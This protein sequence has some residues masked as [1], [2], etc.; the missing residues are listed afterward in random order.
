MVVRSHVAERKFGDKDTSSHPGIVGVHSRRHH[1]F[2]VRRSHRVVEIDG[3]SL[4]VIAQERHFGLFRAFERHV[5][6]EITLRE[7][8]GES[9][10]KWSAIVKLIVTEPVLQLVA[11]FGV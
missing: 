1:H 2:A 5:E 3:Q 11:Y 8:I 7:R 10:G 9:D 6:S 4:L